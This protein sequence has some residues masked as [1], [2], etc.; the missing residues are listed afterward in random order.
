MIGGGVEDDDDEEEDIM[1]GKD[2]RW[3]LFCVFGI[4]AARV[5]FMLVILLRRPMRRAFRLMIWNIIMALV[6][7]LWDGYNVCNDYY[8][9]NTGICMECVIIIILA[10]SFYRKLCNAGSWWRYKVAEINTV[11]VFLFSLKYY[12]KMC[13]RYL[14]NASLYLSTAKSKTSQS[15]SKNI[16][17]MWVFSWVNIL[18]DQ[19]EN[20][21][22]IEK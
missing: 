19:P 13:N 7:F 6:V 10:L 16:W 9:N 14:E 12:L 3:V 20:L 2:N 5:M 18:Y 22:D 15:F 11:T 8:D 4:K 21:K 1:E 17:E